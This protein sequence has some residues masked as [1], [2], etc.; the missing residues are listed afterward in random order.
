M[1][2]VIRILFF[3]PI[4][5]LISL[6]LRLRHWLYDAGI[7]TSSATTLP[8]ICIGNLELG[9]SG[10]TPLADYILEHF[11]ARK[12]IAFLSRGYGR[13]TKGFRWLQESAGPAECGDEPW[14]LFQK[15]GHQTVFAVDENRLRGIFMILEKHP[16][17]DCIL[18]DDAFQHRK[19]QATFSLLLSPFSKPFYR[20]FLFPAGNLRDVR[21]AASRADVL[22]FTKAPAAGP[23]EL[24]QIRRDLE[25]THLDSKKV[26]ISCVQYKYPLNQQGKLLEAGTEVICIA[27]LADNQP[28]FAYCLKYFSVKNCLSMPDHYSYP[29]DFFRQKGIGQGQAILCTEKDLAK[30]TAIA[31]SPELVFYLPIRIRIFP[32]QE[33]LD[34][35]E[36]QIKS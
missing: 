19:V 16:E 8:L 22:L 23:D 32:E 4:H 7:F 12:K 33:F 31:P 6:I 25:G 14:F 1:T 24:N 30:L 21:P 34:T 18:L 20:N 5:L 27:G 2:K 29:T 35:I 11:A 15:Y 17:T 13:K 28:F 36:N 26:F 9:G 3:Y 10:K